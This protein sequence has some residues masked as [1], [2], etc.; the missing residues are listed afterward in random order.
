MAYYCPNCGEPVKNAD[1]FCQS[2]GF[3]LIDDPVD[4]DLTD[5]S[6]VYTSGNTQ[7]K[8]QND[9]SYINDG[10]DEFD[11]ADND[12]DEYQE[13]LRH[14]YDYKGPDRQEFRSTPRHSRKKDIDYE[15]YINANWPVRSKIAAGILAI[16]LGGLGIHKFY[17]GKIG[18]GILMLLFCWTMIPGIIGLVEGILY[19]TMSDEEFSMKNQV[20]VSD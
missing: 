4:L 14:T 15:E 3:Q 1:R 10:L 19:L 17:L 11:E 8:A 5:H 18:Q 6:T 13:Y 12:T 7:A 9:R 2:C 20:R 16:L